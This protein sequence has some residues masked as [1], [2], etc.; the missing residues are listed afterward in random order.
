MCKKMGET[1]R[2]ETNG[3]FDHGTFQVTEIR[4]LADKVIPFKVA[5]KAKLNSRG[6]LHKL[7]ARLCLIRDM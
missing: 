2:K 6:E 4:L 3:L 7:K 1:I 5:L